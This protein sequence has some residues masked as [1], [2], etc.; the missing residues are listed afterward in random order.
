MVAEAYLDHGRGNIPRPWSRKHTWTMVAEAYLDLGR[1]RIPR[2]WSRKHTATMGYSAWPPRCS[3]IWAQMW[4]RRVD[5]C[6][7]SNL[8]RK[9][10]LAWPFARRK[11]KN[12]SPAILTTQ[13]KICRCTTPK[14]SNITGA[15]NINARVTRSGLRSSVQCGSEE[16]PTMLHTY[17]TT[18][19]GQRQIQ[20]Q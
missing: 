2:P 11:I 6:Y 9:L 16:W 13:C 17:H 12:G 8:N 1:R 4:F 15:I 19:P 18:H 20:H 3:A 14:V 5:Q 7:V 10:A